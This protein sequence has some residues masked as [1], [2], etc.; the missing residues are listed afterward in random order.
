M[1]STGQGINDRATCHT[2][3]EEAAKQLKS[4]T[5]A[6]KVPALQPTQQA[7]GSTYQKQYARWQDKGSNGG[8][9]VLKTR[10][11]RRNSTP[12][13]R[14]SNSHG[15]QNKNDHIPFSLTAT[16]PQHTIRTKNGCNTPEIQKA[17]T[18]SAV[19][20]EN[21]AKS[22]RP[23]CCDK[24]HLAKASLNAPKHGPQTAL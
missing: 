3:P 2:H 24:A 23:I 7:S 4:S 20:H 21:A 16:R 18:H 19:Y 17:P 12:A 1:R 14:F 8:Q 22:T 9:S 15:N 5:Y 6:R 13:G 11:A 10:S